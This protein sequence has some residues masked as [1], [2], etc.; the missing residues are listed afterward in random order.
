MNS[1]SDKIGLALRT[2][3]HSYKAVRRQF[4]PEQIV[5][6]QNTKLRKLIN[7]SYNNIKYYHELFDENNIKPSN[8]K[9]VT[10][11]VN[12]PILTKKKLR[13]RFWDFLPRYLPQCRVSRTSG[14]TGIPICLFSDNNSRLYN[15]AAVVRYRSALEIRFLGGAILTPLKTETELHKRPHWTFLQGIHKTFYVNPYTDQDIEVEYAIKIMRRLKKH[16]V[17]G[18]TSAIKAMAYR[19]RD[20]I[21]PSVK[22]S[23][24]LT[25]GEYL[26]SKVRELLEETFATK[27]T[28][29]YACNEAG[30]IA[31]QC[32]RAN[33]YHV[34]ADN[35]VIEILKNNKPV[36]EGQTGEVVI[37]NL[38]RYSTPFIRYKN[39]DLATFTQGLCPCGSKLPIISEVVGRTGEDVFLPSGK[40]IPWNQ[41]KGLMNHPQIRQ[42]QLVQNKNGS[43]LV[44]YIPERNS[45]IQEIEKLLKFRFTNLLQNSIKVK[46]LKVN[47]ITPSSSGKSKLVVSNY[48]PQFAKI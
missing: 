4:I 21:F 33:G 9:T 40:T 29:I 5:N 19:I 37:T 8:I 28:D 38:N 34:N 7:Y 39:G 44:K 48:K 27:I 36:E 12:I 1:L 25:T 10:D 32:R 13:E 22:P 15:S 11:L 46:F 45:N 3:Y 47:K 14:S 26:D 17:I 43:I 42:F 30:D 16:A 6:T 24:V 18:I 20:G 35:C 23:A 41:L 2:Y 31:W